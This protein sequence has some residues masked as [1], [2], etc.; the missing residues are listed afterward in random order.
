VQNRQPL[1]PRRAGLK[2]GD[3]ALRPA[4]LD[5]PLDDTASSQLRARNPENTPATREYEAQRLVVPTLGLLNPEQP[6]V[7]SHGCSGLPHG[8][9]SFASGALPSGAHE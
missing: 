7:H 8:W 2:V 9:R 1:T 5:A 3:V 6:Q 4:G